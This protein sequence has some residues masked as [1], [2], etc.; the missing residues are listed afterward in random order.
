MSDLIRLMFYVLAVAAVAWACTFCVGCG[1]IN[2]SF[3]GKLRPQPLVVPKP[4][5][6]Y[7]VCQACAGTGIYTTPRGAKGKCFACNGSG[8]IE[9]PDPRPAPKP[10]PRPR[11][12][13]HRDWVIG[14]ED[15]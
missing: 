10:W 14:N 12:T 11:T 5:E 8:V 15:L 1:G 6:G 4:P 7:R 3:E 9:I 2:I 13:D